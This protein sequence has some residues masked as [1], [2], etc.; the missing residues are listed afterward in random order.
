MKIVREMKE[1]SSMIQLTPLIDILFLTLVFFMVTMAYDNL[2]SDVDI[3]LPTAA[4]AQQM[5]R[6]Q[7]EIF[8][9]LKSDGSIVVNERQMNIGELQEVLNRVS[10]YFPGGAIIIRGDQSAMLGRAIE[11]LDCCRKADIQN[12][13]FAAMT[14]EAAK[15]KAQTAAPAPAAL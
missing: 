5:E 10:K 1:E 12:V 6:S 14:E 2:E 3:K 15:Q 13:A 4:S 7:G 11:V 8:V 9:N